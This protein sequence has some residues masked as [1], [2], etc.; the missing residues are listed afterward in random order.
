M[1]QPEGGGGCTQ[2]ASS[3]PLHSAVL[4]DVPQIAFELHPTVALKAS[5]G[6]ACQSRMQFFS[7]RTMTC[8]VWGLGFEFRVWGLGFGV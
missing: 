4:S 6:F 8:G 7:R 1:P 3:P 5:K 2:S